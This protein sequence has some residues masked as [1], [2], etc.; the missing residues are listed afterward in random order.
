M[1][2]WQKFGLWGFILLMCAGVGA[3]IA[4]RSNLFPPE[5]RNGSPSPSQ[6]PSPSASAEPPV[7]WTLA[8]T[9]RTSHTYRVGGSC[10]S[11]WRMRAR[12]RVTPDGAIDGSGVAHLL[13]GAAC[14]F[15]TAQ[16]QA[17]AISIRIRGARAG[18]L[19]DLRFRR[20]ALEPPG[21]QDLGGFVRTLPAMRLSIREREGAR[22]RA[23]TRVED[24]EDEIHL[25]TTA[26]L[27]SS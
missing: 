21:S 12:I 16:V 20:G 11:D 25:A 26:L 3:F 24:P 8:L 4:S 1:S 5:V 22:D 10:T 7:R 19:L 17:A 27:L 9:S 23:S 15:P 18:A 13:P 6:T 14:D 2:F